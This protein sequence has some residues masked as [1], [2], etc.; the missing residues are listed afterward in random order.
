MK[1]SGSVLLCILGAAVIL[2]IMLALSIAGCA[3]RT[4]TGVPIG[5]PPDNPPGPPNIPR[6]IADAAHASVVV[7]NQVL[8]V[9]V[10]VNHAELVKAVKIDTFSA[11]SWSVTP[12]GKSITPTY[13]CRG[14]ETE[15]GIVVLSLSDARGNVSGTTLSLPVRRF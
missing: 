2:I 7:H 10:P 11:D 1:P 6:P 4:I 5:V 13:R 12:D 3:H 8:S 15:E 9:T 14:R